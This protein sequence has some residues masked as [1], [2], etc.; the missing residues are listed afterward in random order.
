[1]FRL[2]G[3]A[4][5]IALCGVSFVAVQASA[6]TAAPETPP[7]PSTAPHW[8]E[9]PAAPEN[10][11]TV[12]DIR[13]KVDAQLQKQRQLQSELAALNWDPQEPDKIYAEATSHIVPAM[14]TSVDPAMTPAQVD[15]YAA[16]LRAKA[17]PP[18][19]AQ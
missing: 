11:P 5:V 4:C 14:L 19:I 13:M 1:M 7:V 18:P 3:P 8:S 15:A 6:Q 9:F 2:I 12:A 17:A 10:V 16:N